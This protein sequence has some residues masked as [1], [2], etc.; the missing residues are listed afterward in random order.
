MFKT[1]DDWQGS[2]L[3]LG[4]RL[5]LINA[6]LSS[7]SVYAM[8]MCLLLNTTIKKMDTTRKSFFGRVELL[9]QSTIWLSGPELPS[10]SK[11]GS[12]ELKI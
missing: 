11:K 5:V 1:L 6:S 3:S 9:K 10:L 12:W 7:I 2:S 4:G 8:S